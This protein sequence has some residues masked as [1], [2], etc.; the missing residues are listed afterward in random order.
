MCGAVCA[1]E[2]PSYGGNERRDSGAV[3]DQLASACRLYRSGDTGKRHPYPYFRNPARPAQK[4]SC[5]FPAKTAEKKEE[6]KETPQEEPEEGVIVT[7]DFSDERVKPNPLAE[8]PVSG[9][10]TDPPKKK[11]KKRKKKGFSFDKIS[12]IITFIKDPT[13]KRGI[14]TVKKELFALLRYMAPEK[15]DGK[16]VF[17][18][19]D[20]CTTGW[21]LG[22]VSM[23]PPAYTEGLRICPEFEE[24]RFQAD[25]YVKGKARLIYMVRLVIRGYL[26]PDIKRWIDQVFGK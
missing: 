1:G 13:N 19:G 25:G 4:N 8:K 6:T 12:S 20:P 15:I 24:K 7:T 26:D 2:I 17:G 3:S 21:I 5:I 23:V 18:T 16:V 10:R 11:K 9:D 22:I 14:R